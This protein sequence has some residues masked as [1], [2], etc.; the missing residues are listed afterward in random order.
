M[1][2]GRPGPLRRGASVDNCLP[3]TVGVGEN[4]LELGHLSTTD[5][6]LDFFFGWIGAESKFGYLEGRSLE[7][8][9]FCFLRENFPRGEATPMKTIGKERRKLSTQSSEMGGVNRRIPIK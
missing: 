1:R 4:S 7:A 5:P 8:K 2:V 3:Q 6:P 9:Y